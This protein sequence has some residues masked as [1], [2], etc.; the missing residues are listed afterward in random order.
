MKF[1]GSLRQK[2]ISMDSHH[3][4]FIFTEM[5]FFPVMASYSQTNK[6]SLFGLYAVMLFTLRALP[7]LVNLLEYLIFNTFFLLEIRFLIHSSALSLSFTSVYVSVIPC[8]CNKLNYFDTFNLWYAYIH[9]IG[10]YSTWLSKLRIYI[11]IM[12]I[13]GCKKYWKQQ[14]Y[15]LFLRELHRVEVS[16]F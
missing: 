4:S 10:F 9:F 11:C 7:L 3:C 1:S 16:F 2:T 13:L 6:T 8:W 14:R 15:K 12:S 5:F